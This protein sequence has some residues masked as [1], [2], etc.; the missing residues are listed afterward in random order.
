MKKICKDCKKEKL[1]SEF[2]GV[3]GECKK[4]T[5]KRVQNNYIRNHNHYVEYEK[6]RWLDPQRRL[7]ALEYQRTRRK[8]SPGKDKARNKIKSA[9][10]GGLIQRQ[11]CEKC[12]SI[13]S[14]AH[15]PDYRSPLKILWLCRKHH[16]EMHNKIS[17]N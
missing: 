13:K 2:Y 1:I 14:E 7:K 17:N 9:L 16:L 3:Q 10:R 4:C 6:E 5:Q 12:G 8:K 11:P 15:H